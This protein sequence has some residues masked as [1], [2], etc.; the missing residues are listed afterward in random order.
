MMVLVAGAEVLEIPVPELALWDVLPGL[1]DDETVD[2]GD[3]LVPPDRELEVCKPELERPLVE[4]ETF[5]PDVSVDT[6]P[7]P[8]LDEVSSSSGGGQPDSSPSRDATARPIPRRV[9]RRRR[10]TTTA[11]R[12][13]ASHG[14]A[15]AEGSAH[16]QPNNDSTLESAEGTIPAL[17][18]CT[19]VHHVPMST[20][21][22]L[23]TAG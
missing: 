21:V 7:P 16:A 2:V 13:R 20:D 6:A 12:P 22:P 3:A 18:A 10:N 9:G 11:A 14:I 4:P 23:A 8:P 1:L 5:P 19:P 15:R 17:A